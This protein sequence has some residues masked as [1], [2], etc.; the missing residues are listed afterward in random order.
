MRTV[1]VVSGFLISSLAVESSRLPQ[2]FIGH[3]RTGRFRETMD[4][5]EWI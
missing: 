2:R 1:E 3:L 5:H 4:C